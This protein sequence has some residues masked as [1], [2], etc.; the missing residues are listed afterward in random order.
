MANYTTNPCE[1]NDAWFVWDAEAGL[2]PV[3]V[4]FGTMEECGWVADA[5]NAR[6]TEEESHNAG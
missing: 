3:V 2:P 4:Y 5:M 6:A 1:G